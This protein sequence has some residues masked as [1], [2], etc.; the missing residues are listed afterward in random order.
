MTENVYLNGS[1]SIRDSVACDYCGLH[2]TNH[3]CR[4]PDVNGLRTII[5]EKDQQ[6]SQCQQ[7]ICGIATCHVCAEK[8]EIEGSSARN[9]CLMH[10]GI[11]VLPTTELSNHVQQLPTMSPPS[12]TT[13]TTDHQNKI[14][15]TTKSPSTSTS[16]PS[17]STSSPL[18][19]TSTIPHQNQTNSTDS[20]KATSQPS[21]QRKQKRKTMSYAGQGII[22]PMSM[23]IDDKFHSMYEMNE[24]TKMIGIIDTLGNSKGKKYFIR[25]DYDSIPS[26]MNK[27]HVQCYYDH[28]IEWKN[29]T[30]KTARQSFIDSKI[31]IPSNLCRKKR[32]TTSSS[33]K[34]SF[35]STKQ[36]TTP[37]EK[38]LANLFDVSSSQFS[39]SH[40]QVSS[41]NR[42]Q[43]D[44]VPESESDSDE[45]N[46]EFR[47]EY[48]EDQEIIDPLVGKSSM[49]DDSQSEDDDVDHESSG[50]ITNWSFKDFTGS[51]DTG[52]IQPPMKYPHGPSLHPRLNGKQFMSVTECVE[53]F[54]GLD[55]K[56]FRRI[57]CN[58]NKYVENKL[59]E[60]HT[61]SSSTIDDYNFCGA[62]WKPI[63]LG[64]MARFHGILLKISVDGG[65]IGG[66]YETFFYENN[67]TIQLTNTYQRELTHVQAWASLYMKFYRFKQIRAAYHPEFNK[68][69][70]D[71]CH[72]IRHTIN[73][74]NEASKQCYSWK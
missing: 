53:T 26:F 46:F 48:P 31:D 27:S 66:G 62:K 20:N 36:P 68:S 28:T 71:K 15:S 29:T 24:S 49:N 69:P 63:T 7:K 51:N 64:E 39:P 52:L 13:P 70:F 14:H 32:N 67:L 41:S 5:R 55:L 10:N 38:A 6:Q 30:L 18:P 73:R 74:L 65:M 72:Q 45:D 9:K 50:M 17:T 21:S 3:L 56:Y 57:T 44:E 60:L 19:S 47:S 4:V 43:N 54:G 34:K 61:L 59:N 22:A 35:K 8:Y 23:Y 37:N 12:T 16:S 25:W 58:S 33:T 40:Y 2:H 1:G 42:K 11:N